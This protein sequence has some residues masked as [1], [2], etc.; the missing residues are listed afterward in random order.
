M[1]EELIEI[2]NQE[3]DIIESNL[4]NPNLNHYDI[5]GRFNTII[6]IKTNYNLG[7]NISI[8]RDLKL[9]TK[10]YLHSLENRDYNY[11]QIN[12]DFVKKNLIHLKD[13]QRLHYLEYLLELF[14][15]HDIKK[16]YN[17]Y[18]KQLFN[19]KLKLCFDSF[20]LKKIFTIIHVIINYNVWTLLGVILFLITTLSCLFLPSASWSIQLFHVTTENI[21][22][23]N[24]INTISNV[25][26]WLIGFNEDFKVVPV[27]FFGVLVL[28]FYK[29]IFIGLLIDIGFEQ[30][31]KKIGI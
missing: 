15:K 16:D 19:V 22:N 28:L 3:Y 29:V 9:M 4:N 23:G 11:D 12:L 21:S 8:Y 10:H 14:N 13:Q 30:I 5:V 2:I 20:E 26:L 27:N 6:Q 31:K 18:E 1:R 25:V 24:F 7:Q 17:Y